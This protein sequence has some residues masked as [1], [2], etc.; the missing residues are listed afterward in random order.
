M[1]HSCKSMYLF[2]TGVLMYCLSIY[3][4]PLNSFCLWILERLNILIV[5]SFFSKIVF[6]LCEEFS[7]GGGGVTWGQ[8]WYGC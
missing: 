7:K 2:I 8:F 4:T 6:T 5:L 3:M 1:E